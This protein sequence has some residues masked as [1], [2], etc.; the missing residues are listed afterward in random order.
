VKQ[1]NSWR[2]LWHYYAT[3]YT[4]TRMH[5]SSTQLLHFHSFTHS[6]TYS[7]IHSLTHLLLDRSVPID[8]M[9]HSHTHSWT[10]RGWGMKK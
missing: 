5:Y 2:F 3:T 8:G 4:H 6:L 9:L 1:W 7:L 10:L